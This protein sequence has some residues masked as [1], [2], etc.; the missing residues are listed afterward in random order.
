LSSIFQEYSQYLKNALCDIVYESNLRNYLSE[1]NRKA[2]NL[3]PESSLHR[4][5][6]SVSNEANLTATERINLLNNIIEFNILSRAE[7]MSFLNWLINFNANH[8]DRADSLRKWKS[9]L[10]GIARC[11]I[12]DT[13]G[14]KRI[15]INKNS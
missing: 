2:I 11:P 8:L 4:C 7:I 5:G 1:R 12:K 14:I 10:M 6:Y 15:I 13:V 3:S 9:D